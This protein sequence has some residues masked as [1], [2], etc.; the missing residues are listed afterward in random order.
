MTPEPRGEQLMNDMTALSTH[1]AARL[2]A[3][4][5][6][7]LAGLGGITHGIGE[8][9]QGNVAP[10]GLFINSWTQGPIATN[11]GGE[12]GI[13][14]VPNLLAT[15][16]LTFVVSCA[17][18]VWAALFVQTR[19][20]SWGL[21]LLSVVLLLVG[22]GIG[23]PVIGIL[24]G[25]AGLGIHASYSWWRQ[26]LPAPAQSVLASLW[27][28]VFGLCALNGVFLVLGSV[29]LVSVFGLNAPELFVDSFFFATVSLLV[30]MGLGVAYDLQQRARGGGYAVAC[31]AGVSTRSSS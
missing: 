5:F 9:L 28:W 6:G 26:H 16:I 18:L 27:P 31:S 22:G 14:I 21:I 2:T 11:M 8:I 10:K 12:P 30:T 17:V 7:V 15:G 24:A 3:S 19:Y 25:V 23:P 1:S 20:R 13:T 4:L 29:L